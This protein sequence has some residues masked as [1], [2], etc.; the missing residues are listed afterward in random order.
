VEVELKIDDF[1]KK[2]SV[3]TR[4]FMGVMESIGGN[5]HLEVVTKMIISCPS[6]E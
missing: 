6:K 2:R 5:I 4:A 1:S 3:R